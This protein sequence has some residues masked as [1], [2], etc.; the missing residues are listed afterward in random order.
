MGNQESANVVVFSEEEREVNMKFKLLNEKCT[1]YKKY[2]HDAGWDLC[3]S[4]S[5]VI[6]PGEVKKI[7]AGVCVEIPPGFVGDI[8]PRS[9]ISARGL[10][11]PIGT[12]DAGYTGEIGIILIN[13]SRCATHIAKGERIAQLVITPCLIEEIEIV[14][15]LSVSERGGQGFGSTGK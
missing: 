7:G 5:L 12:V 13:A 8:R 1:P 2:L 11:L 14:D 6:C 10:I 9:S 4:E 15:E 3:S